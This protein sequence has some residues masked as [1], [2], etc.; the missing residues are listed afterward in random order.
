MHILFL[1]TCF[2]Y[3]E[4]DTYKHAVM[5]TI[6][7]LYRKGVHVSVL[8]QVSN[9]EIINIETIP[10]EV[11]KWADYYIVEVEQKITFLDK[12]TTFLFS[13]ESVE[14]STYRSLGFVDELQKIFEKT[15]PDIVQF[16]GISMAAYRGDVK[17]DKCILRIHGYEAPK[18]D[19]LIAGTNDVVRK[20]YYQACRKR[21][22]DWEWKQV[23]SGKFIRTMLYDG[24]FKKDII[25]QIEPRKGIAPTI[26]IPIYGMDFSTVL[27]KENIEVEPNSVFWLGDLSVKSNQTALAWFISSVWSSV[28]SAYPYAKLYIAARNRPQNFLPAITNTQGVY[29]HGNLE[30]VY[31]FMASKETMVLP[32]LTYSGQQM[33]LLEAMAVG[34]AIVASTQALQAVPARHRDHLFI[35]QNAATFI[36]L[37][38]TLIEH[39]NIGEAMGN[40]AKVWVRNHLAQGIMD[41]RLLRFYQTC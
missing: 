35:A 7:A 18:Y 36:Q 10:E 40:H 21:L 11:R 34:N 31:D 4:N 27:H 15:P 20:N 6:R 37:L 30:S 22:E 9:N 12:L 23:L 24:F 33:R 19:G 2:P 3:P 8:S 29:W 28:F 26:Y 17:I 41:E 38:S 5:Q 13:D 39:R 16:E 32:M 1:C 14:V 25:S